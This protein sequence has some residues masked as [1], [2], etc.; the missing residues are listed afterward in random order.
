MLLT[1]R[2]RALTFAFLAGM[3]VAA[4]LPFVLFFATGRIQGVL[5]QPLLTFVAAW[6]AMLGLMLVVDL[7]SRSEMRSPLYEILL[8]TLVLVT[9]LL[10]VRLLLYG[11][12]PLGDLTWLAATRRAVFNF[13]EGVRPELLLV[14]VGGLLWWRVVNM[15]TREMG[16]WS[17]GV[18]FRLAV[19]VLL[20][21]GGLLATRNSSTDGAAGAS[22][23]LV[24][25][26][27]FFATGLAAIALA[28]LDEKATS[29]AQQSSAGVVLP[30]SRLGQ[31]LAATGLALAASGAVALLLTPERVR[32]VLGWFS[33]LWNL[34][35]LVI[36]GMLTALLWLIAP[37]M[38]A[39]I[40]F[41][42]SALLSME[43]TSQQGGESAQPFFDEST[44]VPFTQ[45]VREIDALRY[46][47][48]AL[49]ILIAVAILLVLLGRMRA[50]R[51][52][53][54]AEAATQENL[55]LDPNFL[56]RSWQQL[57]SLANLA[58]RFRPGEGLLDAI[59]IE[60]I[61]ANLSRTARE[62]GFPRQ[63]AQPATRYLPDLVRAF[64][65]NAAEVTRITRAYERVHYGER[66]PSAE[67]LAQ[68]RRDYEAVRASVRAESAE[69]PATAQA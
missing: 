20:V 7:L 24:C 64:P 34:L 25:L 6:I 15:T 65:A 16:F 31:L 11:T 27:L 2:R 43:P 37:L 44:Y 68:T 10:G 22:A 36:I 60:N 46:A 63:P 45:L 29:Q 56:R 14:L 58:S 13:T 1:D 54:E 30:W 48:V 28:R 35:G 26:W 12:L 62:R 19:L 41:F 21:G 8:L 32:M 17:I 55:P 42:R 5:A 59:S 33:W 40:E 39:L 23:A 69:Q 67:E 3:E 66:R 50:R 53:L 49:G 47:L 61:Y 52:A 9:T 38:D 57:R 51:L 18:S 4:V